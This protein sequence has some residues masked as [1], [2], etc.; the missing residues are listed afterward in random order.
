M[1]QCRQPSLSVDSASVDSANCG[2]NLTLWLVESGDEEPQ[3]E[4]QHHSF[5]HHS[6]ISMGTGATSGA[7]LPL[8]NPGPALT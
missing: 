6:L 4:S 5:I 3:I 8:L 1:E 2:S 7:G